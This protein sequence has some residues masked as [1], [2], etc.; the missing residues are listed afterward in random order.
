MSKSL[1]KKLG[2]IEDD[3]ES[4]EYLANK[5]LFDIMSSQ[6][7]QYGKVMI[8][9]LTI[10]PADA[11]LFSYRTGNLLSTLSPYHIKLARLIE[12][13]KLILKSSKMKKYFFK[14]QNERNLIL[15]KLTKLCKKFHKNII[16]LDEK[17]PDYLSPSFLQDKEKDRGKLN[18]LK[19]RMKKRLQLEKAREKKEGVVPNKTKKIKKKP[20]KDWRFPDKTV[21][22]GKA[23]TLTK[24]KKVK[25]PENGLYENDAAQDEFGDL[26]EFGFDEANYEYEENNLQEEGD[27]LEKEIEDQEEPELTKEEKINNIT[28]KDIQNMEHPLLRNAKTLPKLSSRKDWQKKHGIRKKKNKFLLQ[29][30]FYQI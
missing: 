15:D 13:K 25:Q 18:I 21:D 23:K 29:K 5:S 3:D 14:H 12:N 6:V 28:R 22:I 16:K 4:K 26:E 30:G 8:E 9:P 24:Q 2:E 1:I 17:L 19:K 11:E 10:N 20:R 27:L 7:T